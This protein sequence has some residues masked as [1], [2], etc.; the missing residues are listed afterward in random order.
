MKIKV[1]VLEKDANYLNRIVTAFNTKYVDKLE[2]YSFT[3]CDVALS[4]L[5]EAK[6][7]VLVASDVFEIN[8]QKLP[9]RCGF[10]YLVD[11]ADIEVVRGERTVCKFQKA[12]LIYKQILSIYSENASNISGLKLTDHICKVIIFSS[13]CGGT[14]TSTVAAACALNF[15]AKG[16]RVLYLNLEVFGSSDQFFSA[17][18]QFDMSDIIYALKS[19]KANLALKLESCVKQDNRGV[20]FFARP[21]VA[22]DLLELNTEEILRLFSELELSGAYDY[23]IT[24]MSFGLDKHHISIYQRAHSIIM[25]GDGSDI[26][27]YKLERAYS[28]LVMLDAGMEISLVNRFC[29][30]YNQFCN[31]TSSML[32]VEGLKN[33][34]GVMQ[35]EKVNTQQLLTRISTMNIYQDIM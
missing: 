20:C 22:L 3:D 16:K 12:E 7:D 33:I 23:I 14:G 1:A 30:L 29:L 32:A 4:I 27:N 21:K 34:G 24:D 28:S 18:G 25:V 10:A 5:N 6:I 13:P 31:Q 35:F 11:S 19:K 15:A 17:E 8:K 2:I 9:K 26:S